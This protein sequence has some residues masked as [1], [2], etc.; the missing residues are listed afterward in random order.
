MVINPLYTSD[1]KMHT[2][3]NSEDPDEMLHGTAFLQD[4]HI[5]LKQ[6]Q[7]SEKEI[8][9]YKFLE[10]IISD[11]W[12]QRIILSLVYQTRRKNPLVHKGL[13]MTC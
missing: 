3:A 9:F 5:L 12:I 13:K 8:Q 10:I 6:K 11:P 1:S 2:L 7:S 4:L